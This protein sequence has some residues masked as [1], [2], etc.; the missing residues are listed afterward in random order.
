MIRFIDLTGQIAGEPDRYFAWFDTITD[1]FIEYNGYQIWDSWKDFEEDFEA[2]PRIHD[3][4]ALLP[5][6][7]DTRPLSRFR[8]LFR[9]KETD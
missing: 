2:D 7:L 5:G 1:T 4:P 8:G 3:V 9:W 6:I